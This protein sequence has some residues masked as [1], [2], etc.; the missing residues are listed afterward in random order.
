MVNQIDSWVSS[1]R[2]GGTYQ[3]AGNAIWV[4]KHMIV[5][6]GSP[7]IF[8]RLWELCILHWLASGDFPMENSWWE[9]SRQSIRFSVWFLE[10]ANQN[11]TNAVT[12]NFIPERVWKHGNSC[13]RTELAGVLFMLRCIWKSWQSLVSQ[14]NQRSSYSFSC[15]FVVK[16]KNDCQCK[17]VYLRLQEKNRQGV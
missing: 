14:S 16:Y 6:N 4:T 5:W 3:E 2:C 12:N 11:I 13:R 7:C 8:C 1:H 10:S 17:L 9:P 15:R